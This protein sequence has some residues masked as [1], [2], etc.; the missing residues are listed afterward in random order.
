MLLFGAHNLQRCTKVEQLMYSGSH[1]HGS[2]ANKLGVQSNVDSP[3]GASSYYYTWAA[4][5]WF[6]EILRHHI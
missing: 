5:R 1:A 2:G 4:L 6:P 3:S